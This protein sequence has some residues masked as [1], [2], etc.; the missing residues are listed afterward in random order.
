MTILLLLLPIAWA[1]TPYDVCMRSANFGCQEY[2]GKDWPPEIKKEREEAKN[3]Q[4]R[5]RKEEHEQLTKNTSKTLSISGETINCWNGGCS[6]NIPIGIER[7]PAISK[8]NTI[9]GIS[10]QP[11]DRD[12]Q[13]GKEWQCT[14]WELR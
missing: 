2:I 12:I 4:I 11:G 1:E 10:F 9:G 3:E 7:R 6:G 5:L 8:E 13:T 14:R